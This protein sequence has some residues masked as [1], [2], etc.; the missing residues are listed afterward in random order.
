MAAL[1]T[2]IK[3]LFRY[4]PTA[5]ALAEKILE[6]IRAMKR[7]EDQQA[8][9]NA[10]WTILGAKDDTKAERLEKLDELHCRAQGCQ[11]R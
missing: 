6:L 7:P 9:G 11:L 3:F 8:I 5:L 10:L 2:L 1:W 4:G